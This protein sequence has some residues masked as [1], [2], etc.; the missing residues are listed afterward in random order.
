VTHIEIVILFAVDI[1]A[2]FGFV[3][4]RIPAQWASKVVKVV[5]LFGEPLQLWSQ[6]EEKTAINKNTHNII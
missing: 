4:L 2:A 3:L 6:A 5:L 1:T